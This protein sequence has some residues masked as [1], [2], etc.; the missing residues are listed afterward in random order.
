M[1]DHLI[2]EP[3][4]KDNIQVGAGF[5]FGNEGRDYSDTVSTR[6][7]RLQEANN[8][9]LI[10]EEQTPKKE[11]DPRKES[12][13]RDDGTEVKKGQNNSQEALSDSLMKNWAIMHNEYMNEN[14][15]EVPAHSSKVIH[16]C[17]HPFQDM[18]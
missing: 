14:E 18:I 7:G 4:N 10:G 11:Q 1:N 13:A 8:Q 6:F 9:P 5:D 16:H 12:F 15:K 2:E 3:S 17:L